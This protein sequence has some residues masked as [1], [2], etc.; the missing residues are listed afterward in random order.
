MSY[1]ANHFS[2]QHNLKCNLIKMFQIVHENGIKTLNSKCRSKMKF[3][4][5]HFEVNTDILCGAY[6]LYIHVA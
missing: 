1:L 2:L 4:G 3:N 6:L 5:G